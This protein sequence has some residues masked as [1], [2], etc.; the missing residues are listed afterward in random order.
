MFLGLVK[1]LAEPFGSFFRVANPRPEI[2]KALKPWARSA[3]LKI[4]VA[5]LKRSM[6]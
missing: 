3:D 6:S 5:M 2:F 1:G 4:V